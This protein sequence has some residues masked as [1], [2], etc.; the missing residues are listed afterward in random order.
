MTQDDDKRAIE[1]IIARQFGSLNWQP[2]TVIDWQAFAADFIPGAV[3]YP[4][5]RPAKSQTV[6]G[7]VE[8]M[9]GLAAGELQSFSETVLGFDIRVFGNVAV[10]AA[11]CEMVENE[12]TVSRNVEM[13]LLIKSDGVWQIVSQAWDR[14]SETRPVPAD[15]MTAVREVE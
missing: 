14:A 13:M 9:K 8:R 2:G 5:A 7:F 6:E 10:A 4:A 15:L 12:K 11:G 1:A 3:L